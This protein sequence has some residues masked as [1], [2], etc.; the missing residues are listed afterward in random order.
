[1]GK[2]HRL[3]RV[4]GCWMHAKEVGADDIE[5]AERNRERLHDTDGYWEYMEHAR[6]TADKDLPMPKTVP[7]GDE[8]M[9][10]A[11]KKRNKEGESEG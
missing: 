2:G 1:M 3:I 7:E 5:A 6:D 9:P 4:L 10:K 11:G 8:W